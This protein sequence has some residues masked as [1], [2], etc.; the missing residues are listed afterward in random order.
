MP[1]YV[2]NTPN[3]DF[4]V[5][6]AGTDEEGNVNP[7]SPVPVGMTLSVTSDNPDAF[8]VVQDALDPRLVHAVVGSSTNPDGSFPAQANVVANL[9]LDS[10]GSLVATGGDLVTVVAN[11]ATTVTSITLNLPPSNQ[12]V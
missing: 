3:F 10:D 9:T 1:V 12:P 5:V 6:I 4:R 8:S 2:D 7:D 11:T